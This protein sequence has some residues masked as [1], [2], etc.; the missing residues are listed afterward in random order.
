MAPRS[1][2]C[3]HH[4]LLRLCALAGH[5]WMAAVTDLATAGLAGLA[6]A[7][8]NADKTRRAGEKQAVP[9]QTCFSLPGNSWTLAGR[10]GD[11]QAGRKGS[12][13]PGAKMETV[14]QAIETNGCRGKEG[15]PGYLQAAGGRFAPARDGSKWGKATLGIGAMADGDKKAADGRAKCQCEQG[16]AEPSPSPVSKEWPQEQEWVTLGLWTVKPAPIK[17][18]T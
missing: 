10:F 14:P 11:T 6:T 15:K 4:S 7:G 16:A 18:L 1:R 12:D 2:S 5:F 3:R 17:L 9:V 8:G 13:H